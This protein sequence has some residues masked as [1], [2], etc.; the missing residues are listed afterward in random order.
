M[1][2]KSD[3]VVD[4][5]HFLLDDDDEDTQ[6]DKYLSFKLKSESYGVSIKSIIEIVEMQKIAE[7]PEV[8]TYVKGV[9]NLRGKI[10]P[11]I[12]LR[13]RFK[14]VER[15]YDDRTC[16]VICEIRDTQIGLIV[17]TVEEVLEIHAE[18]I[19]PA[20]QFKAAGAKN[21]Y[22]SGLG[23]IGDEVKILLDV[24]KLMNEEEITAI[25]SQGDDT[26]TDK[27]FFKTDKEP[28]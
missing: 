23:R 24:D 27:E 14:M 5:K 12:D 6:A 16:I 9:I 17:D 3:N 19:D 18:N 11:V 26:S 1:P 15:E 4:E 8:P 22:I 20:P 2:N 25:S 28:G 13:L 10:I 21:V 7:V